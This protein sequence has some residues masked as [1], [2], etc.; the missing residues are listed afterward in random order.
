MWI[1]TDKLENI[2]LILNFDNNDIGIKKAL[3]VLNTHKKAF[4][5]KN[6]FKSGLTFFK[7]KACK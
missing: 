7:K 4:K 1:I 6:C 2:I 3:I 5:L